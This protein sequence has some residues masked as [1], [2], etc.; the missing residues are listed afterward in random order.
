MKVLGT[1]RLA[2]QNIGGYGYTHTIALV[3]PNLLHQFLLS[4]ITQKKLHLLHKSWRF[5]RLMSANSAKLT[6]V[7]LIPRKLRPKEKV[8]DTKIPERPKPEWPKEL[9]DLCMKIQDVLVEELESAQQVTCPSM[10]VEL[11]TGAKPFFA[12]R[13]RKNPF[14]WKEKVKKEVQKLIKQGVIERNPSNEAAN[15]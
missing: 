12:Q 8:P 3:C 4:W 2:I 5:I 14:R 9:K 11:Q 10:D 1:C 7:R 13:K 6:E 15:G